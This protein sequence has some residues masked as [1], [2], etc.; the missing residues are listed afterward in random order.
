M[1]LDRAV[2]D[3]LVAGSIGNVDMDGTGW[4]I[5][6]GTVTDREPAR[7]RPQVA[8][9]IV[10]GA[11]GRLLHAGGVSTAYARVQTVLRGVTND[12][13]DARDKALAVRA[14]LHGRTLT[15]DGQKA[16]LQATTYAMWLGYTEQ[17][18]RPLWSL[19]FEA[20]IL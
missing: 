15:V 2:S 1:S 20:S 14:R 16:H 18:R 7:E 13:D 10:G 6:D 4:L 3:D 11:S 12:Y 8:V 9:S 17:D 5:L 19:E